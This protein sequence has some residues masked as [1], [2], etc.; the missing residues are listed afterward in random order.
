MGF[1]LLAYLVTAVLFLGMDAVWLT[2]AGPR[3]YRPEL[4]DLMLEHF[5]LAP[6]AVFYLL[7]VIGILIFAVQPA[8]VSGRWHTA[9]LYGALFGFFAYG[10]YDFTNLATIK[11]WSSLVSFVDL[12]WGTFA[13]GV[14]AALAYAIAAAIL[15]S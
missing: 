5:R 1:Y 14:S 8:A 13:T 15:R 7:Y 3:L 4:G 10:T 9:L 11:G 2:L 6:A 12:A